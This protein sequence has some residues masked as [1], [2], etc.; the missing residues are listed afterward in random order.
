[1]L[2][3]F[4]EWT[5]DDYQEIEAKQVECYKTRNSKVKGFLQPI[6]QRTLRKKSEK[7]KL[8]DKRSKNRKMQ[9]EGVSIGISPRRE[10]MELQT[11]A[12]LAKKK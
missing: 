4:N 10:I 12:A 2:D 1:M 5:Q 11:V 8:T 7:G 6:N 9:L 3:N